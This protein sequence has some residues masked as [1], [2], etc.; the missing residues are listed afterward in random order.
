MAGKKHILILLTGGTLAMIEKNGILTTASNKDI[1]KKVPDLDEIAHIEVV[2]LYNIDSSNIQ[3]H[4]WQKLADTIYKNI[5][6]YDGFVVIHGTDTMVY[7]ASALSFMLSNLSKPVILTGSQKPIAD[8]LS[9]AK[10]NLLY[11]VHMATL[12]IP[13]VCIYFDYTLFRGNRT[14]KASSTQFAAFDSPNYPA[15]VKAGIDTEIRSKLIQKPS[16]LFQVLSDYDDQ[17]M[18]IR[19]FPGM[20]V[21]GLDYL[22][23]TNIKGFIIQAFGMGNVPNED[24]SIIPFIEKATKA[25]KLVAISSQSPQGMVDLTRYETANQAEKAGALSCRDM[26]IETSIVKM[27]FL[28]GQFQNVEAVRSNFQKSLAGE[29]GE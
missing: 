11:A 20:G 26:T 21:D 14:I 29:I 1:L 19:L 17:V 9:D 7:T 6:N 25:G 24:K 4:H 8:I 15:L 3:V 13:E 23:K 18:V 12:E 5:D 10:N 28:F 22:C 27:M 16:G 2:E